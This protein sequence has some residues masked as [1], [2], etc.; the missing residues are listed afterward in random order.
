VATGKSPRL[1]VLALVGVMVAGT[2]PAA[3]AQTDTRRARLAS[4]YVAFRQH[5]D[6]GRM[7]GF[8]PAGSTADAVLALVAARRGPRA[9]RRALDFLESQVGEITSVG[10]LGKVAMA[11]VAGGRNPRDFGGRNLVTAITTAQ[12][13]DGRYGD[14]QSDPFIGVVS[15]ALAMLGLSAAGQAVPANAARWLVEAQCP[16]GGWQQDAPHDP[17]TENEH[18][19]DA[20]ADFDTT[21]DANTTSYAVQ[22][23]EAADVPGIVPDEDP[24]GPSGYFASARDRVR[25]GWRFSHRRFF[26]GQRVWTDANSTA[27]VLQARAAAGK[28]LPRGGMRALRRLQYQLC[29]PLLGGAFAFT[30]TRL[31]DG[32]WRRSPT[33]REARAEVR[34]GGPSVIGATIGAVPALLGKPLPLDPFDVSAAVPRRPR[35]R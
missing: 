23:L 2:V 31:E 32:R 13:P 35:C 14:D 33:A 20:D 4:S 29:G 7:P 3:S 15:H 18:C 28:G 21:S 19:F 5:G 27:L 34:S 16:D 26:A 8:S 24:F 9:I 17:T 25:G 10:L 22:A 1:F 11:A 6:D 12:Q 30:W